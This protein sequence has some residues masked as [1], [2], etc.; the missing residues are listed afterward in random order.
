[1]KATERSNQK[2][3]HLQAEQQHSVP[4]QDCIKLLNCEKLFSV[5]KWS[6]RL[7]HNV[8]A[9]YLKDCLPYLDVL[10]CGISNILLYL[11]CLFVPGYEDMMATIYSLF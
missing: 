2:Q 5:L 9:A 4:F 3:N 6:G 10:T 8:A 11:K 7:F 1:M